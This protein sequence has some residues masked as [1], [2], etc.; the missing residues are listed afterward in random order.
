MRILS[1]T[2]A[3]SL[4]RYLIGQPLRYGLKSPDMDLYD[5]GFGGDVEFECIDGSIHTACKYTIH[6]TG[7]IILYWPNGHKKEYDGESSHTEF[8]QTITRLTELR[9]RRI[10]LSDKNDLW[11]DLGKCRMVIVTVED[12]DESWRFFTPGSNAPH[13]IAT[14]QNL[15]LDED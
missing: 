1:N 3:D 2:E 14:D 8:A 10:A 12:G 15:Y 5:L 6:F 9:V 13:L 4:L 11:L 7:G